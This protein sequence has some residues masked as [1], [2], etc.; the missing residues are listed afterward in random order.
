M[1]LNNKKDYTFYFDNILL[2]FLQELKSWLIENKDDADFT[3]INQIINE[4]EKIEPFQGIN[5]E[6][7]LLFTNIEN[8]IDKE[9]ENKIAHENLLKI[10]E[11]VRI[12]ENN[13]KENA[14]RIRVEAESNRKSI[15]WGV[16]GFSATLLFSMLSLLVSWFH[17]VDVSSR[18]SN[19][20]SDTIIHSTQS[21]HDIIIDKQQEII[22]IMNDLSDTPSS[23]NNR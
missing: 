13:I 7:K 11:K 17:P 10:A 2:K 4:I 8:N 15:R 14:E 20:I 1:F 21:S 9:N 16:M 3:K 23:P 18:S 12:Q 19:S 6:I 5:D 22:S